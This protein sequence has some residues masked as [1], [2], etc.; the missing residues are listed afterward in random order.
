MTRPGIPSRPCSCA[1]VYCL[2]DREAVDHRRDLIAKCGGILDIGVQCE[3][4]HCA[5]AI[6]HEDL[7][8]TLGITVVINDRVIAQWSILIGTRDEATINLRVT[9]RGSHARSVRLRVVDARCTG[10][11]TL[12]YDIE[13]CVTV[14]IDPEGGDTP[15]IGLRLTPAVTNSDGKPPLRIGINIGRRRCCGRRRSSPPRG[16]F[17]I[18]KRSGLFDE[19]TIRRCAETKGDSQTPSSLCS[20]AGSMSRRHWRRFADYRCRY[21]LMY[22][23]I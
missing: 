11:H 21:C 23:R 15:R 22:P 18:V 19:R 16:P 3:H 17:V 1:T 20:C 7:L 8:Q 12:H 10:W 6:S 2:L 9:I 5:L 14:P 13:D 4:I